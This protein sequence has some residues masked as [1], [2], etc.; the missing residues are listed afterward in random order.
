MNCKEC[1]HKKEFRKGGNT[2]KEVM[3]RHPD[4][5]YIVNYFRE[6]RIRKFEG[7]LG[8]VNSKGE[9]PIKTS[10]KWCP[11]KKESHND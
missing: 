11:L 9:F 3:C 5:D 2:T 4:R 6:H 1:P 10:P 7:F 8:Y